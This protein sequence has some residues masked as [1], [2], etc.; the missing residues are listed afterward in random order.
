MLIA[1][2]LLQAAKEAQSVSETVGEAFADL[3]GQFQLIENFLAIF[4]RDR[5]IEDAAVRLVADILKAVEDTIGY[6]M[7]KKRTVLT[8]LI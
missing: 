7:G 1:R 6:Y 2:N 5:P 3:E 8:Y 4:E